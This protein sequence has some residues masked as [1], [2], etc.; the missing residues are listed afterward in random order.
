MSIVTM[1]EKGQVT[2]PQEFRKSLHIVKGDS[3]LIE[4]D[5]QGAIVIRPAAVLAVETYS[6]ARL[7]TF[8]D[9]DAMTPAERRRVQK[10]L[11]A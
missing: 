11:D 9:E 2:I 3:L 5:A 7:K 1:S 10:A 4:M 8:A 6:E